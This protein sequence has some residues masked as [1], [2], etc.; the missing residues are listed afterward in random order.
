MAGDGMSNR[1]EDQ[2]TVS[3]QDDNHREVRTSLQREMKDQATNK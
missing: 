1:D 2:P 3:A